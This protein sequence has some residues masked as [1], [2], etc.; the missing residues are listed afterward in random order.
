MSKRATKTNG[1]GSLVGGS[2]HIPGYKRKRNQ[3]FDLKE[4][5]RNIKSR[6][7]N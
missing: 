5:N 6:Q 3:I 2:Q 4:L 7:L 1:A